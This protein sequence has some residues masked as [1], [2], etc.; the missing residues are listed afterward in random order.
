MGSSA[1]PAPSER[2]D[3]KRAGPR[4][5]RFLFGRA[6]SRLGADVKEANLRRAAAWRQQR[7]APA[8]AR[9]PSPILL[10]HPRNAA[11][12]ARA[13]ADELKA[14]GYEV[15]PARGLN[16]RGRK[17]VLLWS[18]Q[19]W[20]TPSLRAVARRAHA[21]GSLVCIRLDAAPPPVEGARSARL[22][23]RIAWRR[24]LSSETR[25]VPAPLRG[26]ARARI[27]TARAKR[28]MP[29]PQPVGTDMR[30]YSDR[31]TRAFAIVLT[32][33]LVSAAALGVAYGRYPE[34]AAPIDQA[35]AAAYAQASAVAALAP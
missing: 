8:I 31:S 26:V 13:V 17:V 15:A 21:T 7:S 14:L 30:L 19:A 32:L 18:R 34:V 22:A 4:L 11:R 24:L 1:P 29:T 10:A 6:A 35:A 25:P 16:P 33:C 2:K 23:K 9:M 27:H 20:G 28:V 5:A 3:E 12:Q